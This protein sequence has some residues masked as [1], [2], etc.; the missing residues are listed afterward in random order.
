M[1]AYDVPAKGVLE[2]MN[3]LLHRDRKPR[4]ADREPGVKTFLG[5][6]IQPRESLHMA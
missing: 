1:K 5:H 2:E 6:I 4:T 3:Q